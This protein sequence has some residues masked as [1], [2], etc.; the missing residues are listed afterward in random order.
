MRGNKQLWLTFTF[1][2]G[3]DPLDGNKGKVGAANTN[4]MYP[5]Q[6]EYY[7]APFEQGAKPHKKQLAKCGQK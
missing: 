2:P 7:V 3:I 6:W 5:T 1:P 4:V